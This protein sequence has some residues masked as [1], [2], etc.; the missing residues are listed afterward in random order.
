[1]CPCQ[2]F[3]DALPRLCTLDHFSGMSQLESPCD[4]LT[5][6]S[7]RKLPRLLRGVDLRRATLTYN[8][9]GPTVQGFGP[10]CFEAGGALG[11]MVPLPATR[12]GVLVGVGVTARVLSENISM[13]ATVARAKAF[14]IRGL[15]FSLDR[16]IPTR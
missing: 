5:P 9:I 12:D 4:A 16:L 10:G 11:G 1:M 14:F 15:S 13:Q 6:N 3:T 7:K 2:Y 8:T